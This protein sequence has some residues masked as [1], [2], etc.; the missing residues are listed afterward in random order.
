[1]ARKGRGYRRRPGDEPE[2]TVW[3]DDT[4]EQDKK[5][6]EHMKEAEATGRGPEKDDVLTC[7]AIW[8]A[9][10][11]DVLSVRILSARRIQSSTTQN[12]RNPGMLFDLD[13]R[14]PGSTSSGTATTTGR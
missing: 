9:V 13:R 12:R 2:L 8:E 3:I 1:M 10:K 7:R 14:R 4:V 5:V 11:A 6:F